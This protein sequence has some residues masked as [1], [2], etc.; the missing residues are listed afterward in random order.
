MGKEIAMVRL[1]VTAGIVLTLAAGGSA[2]ADIYTWVDKNGITNVSNEA[3]PDGVRVAKVVRTAPKDPAREAAARQ[4]EVRALRDR[5]DELAKEIEQARDV[6]PPYAAAPVMAFAP[7]SPPPAPTVVV[8]VINQPLQA[9]QPAAGCDYGLGTCGVGFF[10][11]YLPG[12]TYYAPAHHRGFHRPH[13]KWAAPRG[14]GSLIPPLIPYP[15][16]SHPLGGRRLG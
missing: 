3:P 1:L 2:R 5:V 8:T 6:P 13:R 4:A 16:M 11:G 12:Y 14:Q 9:E 15:P 10:P 7:P